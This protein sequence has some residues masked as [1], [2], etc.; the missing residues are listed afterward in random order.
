MG[1]GCN[2]VVE[3]LRQGGRGHWSLQMPYRVLC[4][5]MLQLAECPEIA[6]IHLY[7]PVVRAILH[8]CKIGQIAGIGKLVDIDD[9]V[10]GISIDKQAYHM[11]ADETCTAGDDY[12][13]S[14]LHTSVNNM[15]EILPILITGHRFCR[16]LQLFFAD[17]SVP[18]GNFFQTSNLQSLTL[19]YDFYECRGF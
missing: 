19:L 9:P 1:K 17:P 7:K 8:I 4:I 2:A 14:E 15:H 16:P 12:A 6:D 3:S 5:C 11:T 18:V 10:V 13:S